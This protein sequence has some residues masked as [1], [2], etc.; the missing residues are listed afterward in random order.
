MA[1]QRGRLRAHAAGVSAS[2]RRPITANVMAVAAK[3]SGGG[4]A[5]NI[6]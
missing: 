4:G 3:P 5:A 6:Y 1:V 2:D